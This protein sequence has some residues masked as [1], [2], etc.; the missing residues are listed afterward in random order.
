MSQKIYGIWLSAYTIVACQVEEDQ[1]RYVCVFLD[2][3]IYLNSL[4][5]GIFYKLLQAP[6]QREKWHRNTPTNTQI[7][8][9]PLQLALCNQ[10]KQVGICISPFPCPALQCCPQISFSWLIIALTN[11]AL[12][13]PGKRCAFW[14]RFSQKAMILVLYHLAVLE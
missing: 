5:F 2:C 1:P 13:F 6:F 8:P 4:Y 11:K 10:G 7:P 14:S 3:L 12:Q 9:F